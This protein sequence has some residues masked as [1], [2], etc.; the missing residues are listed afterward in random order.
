ML[1]VGESIALT[2]FFLALAATLYVAISGTRAK[3]YGG[4]E[5]EKKE[6]RSPGK[7]LLGKGQFEERRKDDDV[8]GEGG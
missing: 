5:A 6:R 1:S 4:G 8:G 3:P 2:L 7:D